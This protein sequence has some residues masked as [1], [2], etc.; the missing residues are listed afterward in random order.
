MVYS[1]AG[2]DGGGRQSSKL[3]WDTRH[4]GCHM[5]AAPQPRVSLPCIPPPWARHTSHPGALLLL[6]SFFL[7]CPRPPFL[8]QR[9]FPSQR[10]GVQDSI[11]RALTPQGRP[12]VAEL[13]RASCLPP[14]ILR[15]LRGVAQDGANHLAQRNGFVW[16][17]LRQLCTTEKASFPG[18]RDLSRPASVAA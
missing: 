18:C 8:L 17:L 2:R 13:I 7:P 12:V 6:P 15:M 11:I 3:C 9:H 1:V 16:Y 10:R 5:P 4:S 14:R